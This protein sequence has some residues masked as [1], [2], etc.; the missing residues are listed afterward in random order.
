MVT[1]VSKLRGD[2]IMAV[3]YKKLF[4]LMIDDDMKRKDLIKKDWF[5]LC[6]DCKAWRWWQRA[7]GSFRKKL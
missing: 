6:N 3:S 2:Q 4:K 7:D 1:I 5:K